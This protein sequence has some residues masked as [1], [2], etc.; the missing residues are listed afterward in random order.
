MM[1]AGAAVDGP[2]LV[3]LVDPVVASRQWMWR[4]LSS[5]FGVVEAGT[6]QA[7]RDWLD[8]RPEIDAIVV[9]DPLPDGSGV[10]LVADL[11]REGHPVAARAIVLADRGPASARLAP[12]GATLIERGD[13][14]SVLSKLG[15]WFFLRN[16]SVMRAL[17]R[18]AV[19]RVG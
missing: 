14:R 1:S 2:P 17:A 12:L 8:Q 16:S 10:D 4:A 18:E 13:V 19:R 15:Q 3:L 5:G 9:Q 6:A 11:A 7:A